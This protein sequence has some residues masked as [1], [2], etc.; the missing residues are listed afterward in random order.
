MESSDGRHPAPSPAALALPTLSTSLP[1]PQLQLSP[2][3][4]AVY[5]RSTQR[6]PAL[7]PGWIPGRLRDNRDYQLRFFRDNLPILTLTLL[8][9][10]SSSHA[11]C[12]TSLTTYAH[13]PPTPLHPCPPPRHPSS[14]THPPPPPLPLLLPPLQS[15]RAR[16]TFYALFSGAFITFC[17]GS[18][19][20]FMLTIAGVNFSIGRL[21]AGTPL[22]PVLTW[23]FNAGILLLNERFRGYRYAD[24]LGVSYGY[25]DGYRGLF[26]WETLFNLVVLRMISFNIDYHWAVLASASPSP[27]S[28]LLLPLLLSLPLLCL[29]PIDLRGVQPA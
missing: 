12:N 18:G 17:N 14:T 24:L 3:L 29:P 25:L 27:P 5:N 8:S 13:Y 7:S 15:I 1:S 28:S 21:C 2:P 10:S 20:V 11:H 23:L 6:L 16:L 4:C 22:C 9:H 19:V 26:G